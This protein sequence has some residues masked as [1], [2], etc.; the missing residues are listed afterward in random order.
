VTDLDSGGGGSE[1]LLS[2]A[3]SL[4]L[5]AEGEGEGGRRRETPFTSRVQV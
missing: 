3:S 2:L 4:F 5:G 1:A